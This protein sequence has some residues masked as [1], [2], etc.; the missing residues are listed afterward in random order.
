MSDVSVLT[1]NFRTIGFSFRFQSFGF[2][3]FGYQAFAQTSTR[4]LRPVRAG[5]VASAAGLQF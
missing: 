3:S 4:S 5:D 2:Q 1:R